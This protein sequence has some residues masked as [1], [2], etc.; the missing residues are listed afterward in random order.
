MEHYTE[1]LT[2]G[3]GLLLLL[4]GLPTSFLFAVNRLGW[5]FGHGCSYPCRQLRCKVASTLWSSLSSKIQAHKSFKR[6]LF[7]R[8]EKTQHGNFRGNSLYQATKR[9]LN[10]SSALK[11]EIK[12]G[13]LFAS[14]WATLL[15]CLVLWR[16]LAWQ[17]QTRH[18]DTVAKGEDG[19]CLSQKQ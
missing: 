6:K 18:T 4:P 1:E 14:G 3:F 19:K 16:M 17:S 7:I 5:G 8:G 2:W 10:N 15:L 13:R 9:H 12:A 11:N